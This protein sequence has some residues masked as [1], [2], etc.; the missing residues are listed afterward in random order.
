[1]HEIWLANFDE[2]IVV[3]KYNKERLES[4]ILTNY[5][6]LVKFVDFTQPNFCAILYV[7]MC[8]YVPRP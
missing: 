3:L 8:V 4:Q 6:P 5:W 1:M 2:F 7:C